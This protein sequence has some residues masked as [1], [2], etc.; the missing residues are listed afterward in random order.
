MLL[1]IRSYSDEL[2]FHPSEKRANIQILTITHVKFILEGTR[3]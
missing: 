2:E 3:C 1:F